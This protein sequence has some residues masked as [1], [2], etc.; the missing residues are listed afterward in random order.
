M[1]KYNPI[2]N[3]ELPS[4]INT[5]NSKLLGYLPK[6][7]CDLENKKIIQSN[8]SHSNY[9]L[10]YSLDELESFSE[11][12]HFFLWLAQE[13]NLNV[14]EN[15]LIKHE[16]SFMLLSKRFDISTKLIHL[17]DLFKKGE[18]TQI[19]LEK[20]YSLVDGLNQ[21]IISKEDIKKEIFKQFLFSN[22]I[23]NYDLHSNNIAFLINKDGSLNIAPAYD[24]VCTQARDDS[25]R[26]AIKVNNKS[27]D[28]E[29]SD[30]IEVSKKL[31]RYKM[32]FRYIF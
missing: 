31:F 29:A 22:T 30:I 16:N 20:I 12:E 10:K 2:F 5:Q 21:N 18:R 25:T 3:I 28:V 7:F 27:K 15:L 24:I 14:S 23:G 8:Q 6:I 1:K 4:L 17:S 19:T 32:A 26:S 13:C 11:N 9:I